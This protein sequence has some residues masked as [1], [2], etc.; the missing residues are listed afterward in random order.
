MAADIYTKNF[1]NVDKWDEACRLVNIIERDKL[2][3]M[4]RHKFVTAREPK[5]KSKPDS[6]S[7]IPGVDAKEEDTSLP[8]AGAPLSTCFP[9]RDR[10]APRKFRPPRPEQSAE[11]NES[12]KNRW[13]GSVFGGTMNLAQ[14]VRDQGMLAEGWDKKRSPHANF[15]RKYVLFLSMWMLRAG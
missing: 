7:T 5:G 8:A 2:D 15:V 13:F 10:N 1:V 9:C 14:A 12:L 11:A 6:P 3:V 4:I